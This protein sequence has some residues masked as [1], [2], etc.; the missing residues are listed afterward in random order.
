MHAYTHTQCIRVSVYYPCWGVYSIASVLGPRPLLLLLREKCVPCIWAGLGL[1][2]VRPA[3]NS[4]FAAK[5]KSRKPSNPRGHQNRWH[6]M[7]QPA[8]WSQ[9]RESFWLGVWKGS[10]TTTFIPLFLSFQEV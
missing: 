10:C 4:G 3:W 2:V 5:T 8:L 1:F 6:H 9:G 7:F